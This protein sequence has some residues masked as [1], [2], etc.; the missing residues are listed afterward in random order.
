MERLNNKR[1]TEA[2]CDN[3]LHHSHFNTA[4]SLFLSLFCDWEE[5]H[6]ILRRRQKLTPCIIQ[7]FW[8]T[9]TVFCVLWWILLFSDTIFHKLWGYP[10]WSLF[11]VSVRGY[12]SVSDMRHNDQHILK[13]LKC[14]NNALKIYQISNKTTFNFVREW[15]LALEC[16][17]IPNKCV[18]Y[19]PFNDP[20]I[21]AL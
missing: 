18:N 19:T 21:F 11:C 4:L 1:K 15:H 3:S 8:W 16:E 12:I 6:L 20:E 17:E 9:I 10:S 5:P 7:S 13:N 14:Y 2:S